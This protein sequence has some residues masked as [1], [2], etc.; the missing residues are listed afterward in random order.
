VKRAESGEWSIG[1]DFA[2]RGEL[3]L[4]CSELELVEMS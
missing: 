3:R 2:S 1:F 4:C